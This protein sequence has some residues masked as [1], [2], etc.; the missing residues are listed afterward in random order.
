[1]VADMWEPEV[2][3]Y[4]VAFVVLS[5]VAGSVVAPIVGGVIQTYLSWQWV[6]W[7]QLIFG[8]VAQ[9][10]HL[11]VPETR[12]DVLLDRHAKMLRKTGTYVD[13]ACSRC[14]QWQ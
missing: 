8:V 1:M 13:A 9:A 4:A 5:S 14:R 12:S 11:C 7:I 2:Q 3:Q 10:I 6:F